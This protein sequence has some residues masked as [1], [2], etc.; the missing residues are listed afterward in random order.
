[1]ALA[2]FLKQRILFLDGAM[3]TMIQKHK[4]NEADYRGSEFADHGHLL[5]GCNDL[6]T[7]T[8]PGIIR[9]IHAAYFA[10]GSDIVG[11]IIP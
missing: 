1:M 11:L 2:D 3:G 8:Q 10:A 7:L 9:D 6:L 5:K 4:L